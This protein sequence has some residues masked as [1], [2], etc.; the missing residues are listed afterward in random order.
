MTRLIDADELL[1]KVDEE[2][3][4]LIARG[5]AGAEHILV[6]N[7]RGLVENAPTVEQEI[8][9]N[10]KDFDLYLEGYKVGKKHFERPQGEWIIIDDTEQFIAKCSI[11]GR[12]EDSRMIKDYP[13][14]HCGAELKGGAKMKGDKE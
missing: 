14:C 4:Y 3:K 12:I 6:H 11:C 8:Y 7:F 10:G 13:F 2:R 1:K 9:M 5:Q